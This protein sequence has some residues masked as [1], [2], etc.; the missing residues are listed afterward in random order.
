MGEPNEVS[1]RDCNWSDVITAV[2][3]STEKVVGGIRNGRL[4]DDYNGCIMYIFC[5]FDCSSV[6]AVG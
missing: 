1:G 5:I 6:I 4:I 3:K 2:E